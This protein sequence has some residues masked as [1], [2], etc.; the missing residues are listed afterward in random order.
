MGSAIGAKEDGTRRA[1]NEKRMEW[2]RFMGS[3]RVD[4][5]LDAA[6]SPREASRPLPV[7]AVSGTSRWLPGTF[8]LTTRKGGRRR[9]PN[10]LR[11]S[12]DAWE[13][14]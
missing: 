7:G 4:G 13:R 12:R 2:S 1:T 10:K 14:C 6:G 3:R 9:I 11:G 8:P 5:G